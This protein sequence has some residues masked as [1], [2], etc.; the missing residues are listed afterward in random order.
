[1]KEKFNFCLIVKVAFYSIKVCLDFETDRGMSW[2]LSTGD[3]LE[4]LNF[5]LSNLRSFLAF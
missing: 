4:T 1:M 5:Y 3:K 2:K